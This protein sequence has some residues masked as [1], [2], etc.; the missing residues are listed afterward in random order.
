M[1][2]EVRGRWKME[3][4]LEIGKQSQPVI[5]RNESPPR[6]PGMGTG[7]GNPRSYI[8]RE[9]VFSVQQIFVMHHFNCV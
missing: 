9:D 8:G 1:G 7:K 5:R 6:T 2:Q 4:F 3:N